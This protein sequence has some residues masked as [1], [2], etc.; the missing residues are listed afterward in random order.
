MSVIYLVRHGQASFGSENY[1]KLSPL[2]CTQAEMLGEYFSHAG[3]HFDAAYAGDLARQQKTARLALALQP[4]VREPIID[5]RL[6]EVNNDEHFEHLL[7]IVS[8]QDPAI[9]ALL[10]K[11]L[12]ESRDY[13]KAIEA[14]FNYWV[15]ADCKHPAIQSWAD[16]STDVLKVFSHI[17]QAEGAGKTIAVFSSGGTIATAVAQ[18]LEL[19]GEHTYRF[20]EPMMNCSI[21]QIIYGSKKASLSVFNDISYLQAAGLQRNE[22]KQNNLVTYR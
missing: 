10:E 3:I 22:H 18:V 8:A 16:F 7:P 17:R 9:Q 19:G 6:N 11:G 15:S 5:A 1:D 21:T 14:V 12:R 13:Q 2:G 20:Y 4:H